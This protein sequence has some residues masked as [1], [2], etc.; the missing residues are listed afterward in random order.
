MVE[1]SV[2]IVNW[3]TKEDLSNCL[4]S[5]RQYCSAE[6]VEIIVVD[7]DSKD[8]SREMVKENFPDVKVI[9]TGANLGFGRANNI[10]IKNSNAPLILFLNPDTIVVDDAINRMIDFMNTHSEISALQCKIVDREGKPQSLW[11]NWEFNPLTE[12]LYYAFLNDQLIYLLRFFLPF[13]DPEKSGFIK[14]VIGGCLMVRKEILQKIG[15]FDERFFLYSED[16]DLCRMIRNH[17]GK[18]FYN[19][20]IKIIH[21]GGTSS[22][23]LKSLSQEFLYLEAAEKFQTKYYGNFGKFSFRFTLL[24]CGLIKFLVLG[25]LWV[26]RINKRFNYPKYTAMILW[27]LGLGD[28]EKKRSRVSL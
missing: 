6:R 20:E 13:N 28:S 2:I 1:L 14:H 4:L 10:G 25:I 11:L 8:G 16:R 24:I 22:A 3:N 19:A 9:N 17:G 18:I 15:G 26:L 27:G 21:I 12:F 23:K 5:I 7:N